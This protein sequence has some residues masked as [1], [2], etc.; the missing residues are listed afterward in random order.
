MD[1]PYSILNVYSDCTYEEAKAAYRKA[2][3]LHHPD[4]QPLSRKSEAERRFRI[5]S[6]AF[7]QVCHELGHPIEPPEIVP[8]VQLQPI[9]NKTTSNPPSASSKPSSV[10]NSSKLNQSNLSKL[11]IINKSNRLNADLGHSS[12]PDESHHRKSL[13]LPREELIRNREMDELEQQSPYDDNDALDRPVYVHNQLPKTAY[14]QDTQPTPQ[15]LS[16]HQPSVHGG[17][18]EGGGN[19]RRTDV[20][21]EDVRHDPYPSSR[22]S[23][24]SQYPTSRRSSFSQSNAHEY[25]GARRRE[26]VEHPSNSRSYNQ[27]RSRPNDLYDLKPMSNRNNKGY[28]G[29]TD[30]WDHGF[31]LPVD[32]FFGP[33]SSS[34]PFNTSNHKISDLSLGFD[35]L[36]STA[37]TGLKIGG[38]TS[39]TLENIG[40]NPDCMM[41]V[42][43][44]KTVMGQNSDGSWSGQK[45]DKQMRVANGRM[46]INENGQ[47]IKIGGRH[48]PNGRSHGEDWDP[49]PAY[50]GD[51]DEFG[52]DERP[53]HH[54]DDH[55]PHS[56]RRGVQRSVSDQYDHRQDSRNRSDQ[57]GLGLATSRSRPNPPRGYVD[58]SPRGYADDR[59][60]GYVD[61]G[62]DYLED[63]PYRGYGDDGPQRGYGDD[64]PQRGYG[65]DGP[66]RGYGD[67]RP[68]R[69]YG[70]DGPS[71]A[72]RGGGGGG[73]GGRLSRT[74][75]MSQARPQYHP[76]TRSM[77]RRAD[78]PVVRR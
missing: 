2:A 76:D 42:R 20:P 48:H 8:S 52:H 28:K 13:R 12:I 60:R 74:H 21:N 72:Y 66:Q 59:V 62:R 23:I 54:P 16:N 70:D 22:R 57:S 41:R 14:T 71:S 39:N 69:G 32:D 1:D 67:D 15:R 31:G 19:H 75:S 6:N 27:E 4:R 65:D 18:R 55:H 49:P 25:N 3:L 47:E 9:L 24:S 38:P 50:E 56:S 11:P 37:M 63:E 51:D 30:E 43:Q 29:T 35:K 40:T 17:Y 7:Q 58:D 5:L 33:Q 73:A 46:E 45:L 77:V 78:G 36:L 10:T 68:Q 64:R 26:L 34:D 44:S 53:R 61:D